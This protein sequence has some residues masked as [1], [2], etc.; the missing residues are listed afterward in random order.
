MVTPITQTQL[1]NASTDANSLER[2]VNGTTTENSTGIVTTRL[3]Q[4]VKTVAKVISDLMNLDI[5]STMAAELNAKFNAW[6]IQL[7]GNIVVDK[8]NRVVRYMNGVIVTH[9]GKYYD[10][11]PNNYGGL[12]AFELPFYAGPGSSGAVCHYIDMSLVPGTENPFKFTNN[13]VMPDLA[14]P[15]IVILGAT[16]LNEYQSFWG[17]DILFTDLPAEIQASSLNNFILYDQNNSLGG[18]IAVYIPLMMY[19]DLPRNNRQ[20]N[21]STTSTTP[22]NNTSSTE[23]PGFVK[24]DVSASSAVAVWFDID[25]LKYKSAVF[26]ERP[27]G[28][29]SNIV[30]VFNK[31]GSGFTSPA[32]YEILLYDMYRLRNRLYNSYFNFSIQQPIIDNTNMYGGGPAVYLPRIIRVDDRTTASNIS[33]IN[34]IS[35]ELYDFIKLPIYNRGITSMDVYFLRKST[36]EYIHL[37]YNDPAIADISKKLDDIVYLGSFWGNNI[38]SP[39]VWRESNRGIVEN[40]TYYGIDMDSMP[41][42]YITGNTNYMTDVTDPDLL[43]LGFKRGYTGTRP[44]IGDQLRY[45]QATRA[46]GFFRCYI[47]SDTPNTFTTA[48]VYIFTEN[49][50]ISTDLFI[51]KVISPTARS[52]CAQVDLPD[53]N[54]LSGFYVGCEASTTANFI[55]TGVQYH[56]S[57][58]F[59]EWIRYGDYP[60]K[61]PSTSELAVRDAQNIARSNAVKNSL[62]TTVQR[63][64]AQYNVKVVYGQSLGMGDQTTPSLSRINKFG[65]L[66]LGTNVLP[67][68]TESVVGY[69]PFTDSNLHPLIAQA[70]SGSAVY[71]WG[72]EPYGNARGEPVNHGWVNFGKLLH[73][74]ETF[75]END[76]SRIFVTYNASVSGR[77]IE[78]LSKVNTQDSYNRYSRF[79]DGLTRIKTAGGA[80]T[81]VMDGIMWMQGEWNYRDTHGGSWDKATYKTLFT[82]LITDMQ[83][84]AVAIT[85]QT[86]PPAFFTYQTGAGYTNDT[87]SFGTPGLHIGMAQLEVSFEHSNTWMVGPIYQYTDFGGHLTANGS[88]WFGN[89]IA[90]VYHQVV[91]RG[92]GWEPLHP[93]RIIQQGTEIYI[94]FHVPEPPLVFDVIYRLTESVLFPTRGFSVTDDNGTVTISNVELVGATIVKLSL[95]R[96]TVGVPNVWYARYQTFTG[97]GNLRDSDM[98]VGFDNY[99]YKPEDGMDASENIPELVNK[100]YPLH[101]WCVAF[102]LPVGYSFE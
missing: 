99:V 39:V 60:S 31:Y 17:G 102:F 8:L 43:A 77:T 88:R 46:Q 50:N 54:N 69:V 13:G 57:N 59:A 81:C 49:G 16:Y 51:E 97:N 80:Q 28:T 101:N 34:P 83:T 95:A 68:N 70:V 52:Y 21:V 78:Q 55:V 44:Y 89:Q 36:K 2:I 87:D 67:Q 65:N 19:V 1:E 30:T 40:Q 18:G 24:F 48:R 14:D 5:S 72:S 56:V 94:D 96:N 41:N 22:I 38:H 84:D 3:G 15:N 62:V 85:G 12:A 7:K 25:E 76:I 26:N 45:P 66:T 64:T 20:I 58:A 86:L 11:N 47:Q 42:K 82:Q 63:P 73:N 29:N 61:P 92:R 90:K 4:N 9:H 6:N 23:L 98:S 75:V 32:G 71:Q 93:L 27:Y 100:P 53:Y 37:L 33:V 35:T 91:R 10:L 79:T 74:F